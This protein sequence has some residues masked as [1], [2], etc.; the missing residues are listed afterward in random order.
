MKWKL[1]LALLVIGGLAALFS[2]NGSAKSWARTQARTV[3]SRLKLPTALADVTTPGKSNISVKDFSYSSRE[4]FPGY[5]ALGPEE[6]RAVG[7]TLIEVQPQKEP[8]KLEVMGSTDYD[9]NT[10]SQVR[11]RF[12]SK[13]EK[14]YVEMGQTV[15]EGDPLVDIFSQELAAAKSDYQKTKAQWEHDKAELDR[16][17]RLY[18][19][20]GQTAAISQKE[21]LAAINDEKK[22][23]TEHKLTIDTLMVYG[24]SQHAIESIDKEAG[25]EK[26]RFTLKAPAGGV[27]IRRDAVKGNI[28]EATD[29]LLT[30]APLDHFWVWG[31]VYPSDAGKVDRGQAWVITAPFLGQTVRSQ[32][33][34][35]TSDVDKDTK[36]IRIRT[37]IKNLNG[38]L[39]AGMLVNSYVELPR[40]KHRPITVI[41]REAM[42]SVD[43]GDY[44]FVRLS[45]KAKGK[46]RF[47][48]KR[49][50][51]AK[52]Y[53]D[54]V[55]VAGG[56][57]AGQMI[58]RKGS[59]IL[60]Q[61]YED[62][63]TV[64]TG[65]PL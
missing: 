35:I 27:V 33:D 2:L 13:I 20:A 8:I 51:V 45:G 10:L 28:Y 40:D 30:I 57:E 15:K 29:V 42:V 11:A 59:L 17:E 58:V 53:N 31:N 24:L 25:A 37:S 32:I 36:T 16:A 39:K 34:S 55:F 1:P 61:M 19:P 47:E 26:A 23:N 65:T 50:Q 4:T 43:G 62:A 60:A 64:A 3:L 9:P 21:Y 41:P 7:L 6:Q 49:I 22:S 56:I 48:R 12:K 44:V 46:D 14:V 63:A 38:R 5:V 52:E 18:K 54:E